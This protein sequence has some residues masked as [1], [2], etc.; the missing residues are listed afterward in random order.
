MAQDQT[1]RQPGVA[2]RELER[3]EAAGG[4]AEDH[5]SLDA[6]SGAERGDVVGH[7]L[8]RAR[9][10]GRGA[11]AALAAQV[12]EDELRGVGQGAQARA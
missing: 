1:A 11:G 5:R 8:E 6:Q 7:L 12:D 9:L 4:V 2:Q 3:H 10:D